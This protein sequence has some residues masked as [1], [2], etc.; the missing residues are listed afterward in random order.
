MSTKPFWDLPIADKLLRMVVYL[1]SGVMGLTLLA[2]SAHEIDKSFRET[3]DHLVLL[4]EVIAGN[5]QGALLFK[6]A[7]SAEQTLISLRAIPAVESAELRPPDGAPLAVYRRERNDSEISIPWLPAYWQQLSVSQPVELDGKNVGSLE[8]KA[9]LLPTWRRIGIS[10]AVSAAILFAASAS[11]WLLTRRLSK[12]LTQPITELST[13]ARR[14]SQN[15]DADVPVQKRGADEVGELVDAFNSMLRRIRRRDAELRAHRDNLKREVAQQTTELRKAMEAAQAASV[16]K[17]QFLASMS[18][19]IRTPMNA[20]IGMA[21]LLQGTSLSEEQQEYVQIFHSAGESLLS[22]I[23]D[24]LD[25]SKVEAG[26]IE[27]EQTLFD[28]AEVVEGAC[29][30]MSIRGH[31][32][33]L[34]VN[35]YI[36]PDAQLHVMGDPVRLRQILFNLMGNAIKFTGKGEVFLEVRRKAGSP[37]GTLLFSVTDTGIGIAPEAREQI[38][39]KFSQADSSTTRLY[40]GTGLGLAISKSLVELMD[41]SIWLE[42]AL[43]KGST[44]YFTARFA[45]AEHAPPPQPH[46]DQAT[47][48]GV[49]TLVVDDNDTNRLILNR[50]LTGWGMHVKEAPG[51]ADGLTELARAHTAGEPYRL[52]LL[53]CRMPG[54]D[55]FQVASR[56]SANPDLVGL[57]MM[58]LTSDNRKND[59]ERACSFGIDIYMVKPIKRRELLEALLIALGARHKPAVTDRIPAAQPE[60][61]ALNILLVEDYVHNRKVVEGYLKHTPAQ[62]AIAVNGQAA[63]EI[64]KA[65]RYDIVLMDM[66]MPVMDGYSAT[67]EIRRYERERELPATPIVALSA[68]ALKAEIDKSLKA[69]CD[70]HLAKPV[71]KQALLEC[72]FRYCPAAT[73]NFAQTQELGPVVYV[74]PV[75]EDVIP[76]FFASLHEDIAVMGAALERGDFTAIRGCAHNIKGAGGGYNFHA[77]SAIA[78]ETEQAAKT[79]DAKHVRI[80][81]DNLADYLQRVRVQYGELNGSVGRN[82]A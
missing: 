73:A 11:A 66:Q 23:D 61:G 28:L 44:F 67:R 27:L 7:K 6:D 78:Q 43:G 76:E 5:T 2:E 69:G 40:G 20:I 56:I 17:S 75:F 22:I 36:H 37:A 62:I 55:G 54:M 74:D 64:F 42:S 18:H 47:L 79:Q 29:G 35:C 32:K 31:E 65:G 30:V 82:G 33:G 4:A 38:F 50:L 60:L 81:L 10:L 12:R 21:D 1:L 13:A 15:P 77:I 48:A 59:A 41:G 49:K 25:F 34:E 9:N 71:K 14:L 24:I 70:A 52:L 80:T 8:V 51:G 58:M 3:R 63:V 72:L 19:E 46:G 68:F 45:I 16:A 57:T 53:D 26:R 39:D